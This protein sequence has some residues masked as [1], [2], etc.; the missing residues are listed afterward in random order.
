MQGLLSDS[1][2]KSMDAMLARV[3]DP[4]SYQA[5]QHFITDAPWEA[6][7]VWRRLRALL[8]ERTGI[9][10]FIFDGTSFPQQGTHSVGVARQY[11]GTLGKLANCQVAVTAA[12]WTHARAYLL[13]DALYLPEEWLTDTARSTARIPASV[14]FQEK[15]R[16]GL[17][18]GDAW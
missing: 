15:W 6:D 11:S 3:T 4:G 9:F 8:P 2:R 13:G 16:L 7:R 5:F 1:V 17:R 10:I 18:L 12:L 14:T